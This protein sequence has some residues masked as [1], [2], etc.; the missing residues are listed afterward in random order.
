MD[1]CL[2]W[3]FVNLQLDSNLTELRDAVMHGYDV[4]NARTYQ[5]FGVGF[6]IR[7]MTNI[8]DAGVYVWIGRDKRRD[9]IVDMLGCY[10]P[11]DIAKMCAGLEMSMFAWPGQVP[12]TK[13]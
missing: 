11:K 8:P 4:E 3:T 5:G 1:D 6:T 10:L 12:T 2:H 9:A 7:S 13:T